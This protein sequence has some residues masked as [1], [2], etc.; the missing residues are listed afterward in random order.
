[1]T[2]AILPVLSHWRKTVIVKKPLHMEIRIRFNAAI[3]RS[4]VTEEHERIVKAHL[5]TLVNEAV[6]IVAEEIKREKEKEKKKKRVF[7]E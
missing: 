2:F 7:A 3:E 5:G 4:D 6:K 1:L